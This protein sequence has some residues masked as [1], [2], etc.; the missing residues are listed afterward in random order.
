VEYVTLG[1]TSRTV[2]RIGFGGAPAGLANY[3]GRYSP[4]DAQRRGEVIEAIRRAVELGITYFDTAADYGD[5]ASERIFGEAL[6]GH[7]GDIFLATKASLRAEQDPRPSVEASLERLG[8]DCVDPVQI[9]GSSYT[10]EQAARILGPGGMLEGLEALRA[11][12]LLRYIGFTTEDQNPAVYDLLSSGRFDVIQLCYNLLVQHPAE[13]T[14]PF[15]SIYEAERRG[16]GITVMRTL[17]SGIFQ[18]WVRM[19]NPADT[20]DYSAALIQFV[21]SNPLVDVALVGMRSVDHVERNVAIA[22]DLSGRIDLASLHGK[23]VDQ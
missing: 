5:G 1:Q 7:D 12:G 9:H 14:R 10:A 19:A 20:F 15:G 6:R 8:R 2:S 21:L 16:L 18:R 23:Y 13:Q 3:L 4:E 22:N 11:E 17:T